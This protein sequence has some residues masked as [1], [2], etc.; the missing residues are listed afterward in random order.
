MNNIL[1]PNTESIS[2]TYEIVYGNF[3]DT[4]NKT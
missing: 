1:V 3:T 2:E 4:N